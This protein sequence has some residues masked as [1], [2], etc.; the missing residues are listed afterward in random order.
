MADLKEYEVVILGIPHTMLLS[1]EDAKARGV[2]KEPEAEAV[3]P[4]AKKKR[5]GD[6][7]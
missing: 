1:D 3:E 4:S 5:G 7:A 2:F 6:G